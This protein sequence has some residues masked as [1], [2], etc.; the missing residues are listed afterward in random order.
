MR[1]LCEYTSRLVYALAIILLFITSLK[2]RPF[3]CTPAE[4]QKKQERNTDEKKIM[5]RNQDLI[6]YSVRI[7][8]LKLKT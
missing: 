4:L 5:Y 7:N 1:W 6:A 2:F 3:E 8:Q